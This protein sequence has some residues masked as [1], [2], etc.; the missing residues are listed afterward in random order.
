MWIR[1]LLFV[2]DNNVKLNDFF[3]L[4]W[5]IGVDFSHLVPILKK[6]VKS[7]LHDIK[8][9]DLGEKGERKKGEKIAQKNGEKGIGNGNAQLKPPGL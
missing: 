6:G 8:N 9:G 3:Q 7:L 5:R 1:F 4:T 2:I